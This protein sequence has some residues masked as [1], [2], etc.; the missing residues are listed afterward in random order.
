MVT[1]RS[2]TAGLATGV[3]VSRIEETSQA[4]MMACPDV[5]RPA[6]L[7]FD[8]AGIDQQPVEAARL[9]ATG[10]A[11]EQALAALENLLLLGKGRIEAQAA[12]SSTTS[13]R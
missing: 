7:S 8:Q 13:G 9:G 11:V 12:A 5:A 1:S 3:T 6:R 10:A 2:A 4:V